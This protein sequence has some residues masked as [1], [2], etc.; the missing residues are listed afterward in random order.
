MWGQ[1]PLD[2]APVPQVEVLPVREYLGM[3]GVAASLGPSPRD[4]AP[5]GQ[6]PAPFACILPPPGVQGGASGA[7]WGS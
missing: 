6:A 5:V 1:G 4:G 7:F 3:W 2:H